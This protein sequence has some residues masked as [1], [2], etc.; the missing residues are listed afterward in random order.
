MPSL[1]CI[2]EEL[3][4]KGNWDTSEFKVLL[5]VF[6]K[7]NPLTRSTCKNEKELQEFIKTHNFLFAY[8]EENLFTDSDDSQE[9]IKKLKLDWNTIDIGTPYI[10]PYLATE[11]KLDGF[12]SHLKPF[13]IF[14]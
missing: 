3:K 13:A 7:C 11:Y 14:P 9:L 1:Q 4:I 8:N 6:E 5:L 10:K 12:D 2:D